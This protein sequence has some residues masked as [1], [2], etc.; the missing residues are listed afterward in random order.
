MNIIPTLSHLFFV[1]AVAPA[2]LICSIHINAF[3]PLLFI[4]LLS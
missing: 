3:V 2:C 1:V 4:P